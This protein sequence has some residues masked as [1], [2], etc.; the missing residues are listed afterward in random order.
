MPAIFHDYLD[1]DSFDYNL[2]QN[3]GPG[4]LLLCLALSV[5]MDA[6]GIYADMDKAHRK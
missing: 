2:Q 4:D 3:R 1:E 5:A 6:L